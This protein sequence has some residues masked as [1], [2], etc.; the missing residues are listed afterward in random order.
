MRCGSIGGPACV[1]PPAAWWAETS[2][3][4]TTSTTI[5]RAAASR[6]TASAS[7]C[8]AAFMG[9]EAKSGAAP[10]Q[11]DRRSQPWRPDVDRW[12]ESAIAAGRECARALERHLT[13]AS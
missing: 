8:S 9:G 11:S 13:A 1:T 10:V 3:A 5:G 4:G 12:Y 6:A 2:E 7:V